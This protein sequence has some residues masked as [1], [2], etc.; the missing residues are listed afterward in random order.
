MP[1][2]QG[3]AFSTPR[4]TVQITAS[5]RYEVVAG[6]TNNATTISVV[7][8][9]AHVAG[10]GLS[11]DI[12]PQQTGTITGSDTLQGSVG[13]LAQDAFLQAQLSQP[14]VRPAAALPRQA[15][16]MTGAADLQQ[17][18]SF[19]QNA[20]YGAVWYPNDVAQDWAPYRDGH[21][22]YVQPWGWTWVDN[23]RWGFAPFH[24][25]RWVQVDNRW[26]W[27]AG[28]AARWTPTRSIPRRW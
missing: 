13:P 26:G 15:R 17:Y 10:P 3:V 19:S 20:Q 27:I 25:G 12:G 22:A 1:T 14:V 8:G 6:D 2:P 16:Y 24:Y 4:G 28:G 5:G 11:L 18:G 7:E 23:A 9:A 21:W